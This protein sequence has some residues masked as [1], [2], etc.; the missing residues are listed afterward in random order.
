M[1]GVSSF[2]LDADPHAVAFYERMGCRVV[3]QSWTGWGR[4]VPRMRYEL[5]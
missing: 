4:F 3:G 5:K 2:E 1:H